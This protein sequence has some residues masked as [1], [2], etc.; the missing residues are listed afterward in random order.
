VLNRV[1]CR[2]AGLE[3]AKLESS[4]FLQK[5]DGIYVVDLSFIPEKYM[6][7]VRH[8]EE[9]LVRCLKKWPTALEREGGLYGVLPAV[10]S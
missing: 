2:L 8:G 10:T 9:I 3:P 5:E 1:Y 7:D 6:R 4:P